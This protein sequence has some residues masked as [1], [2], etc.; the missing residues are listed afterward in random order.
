MYFVYNH[1]PV[2]RNPHVPFP[3]PPCCQEVHRHYLR[4]KAAAEQMHQEAA[5]LLRGLNTKDSALEKVAES[6]DGVW[7]TMQL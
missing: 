3:L 7:T 2:L 5:T 6:R 1:R 4:E